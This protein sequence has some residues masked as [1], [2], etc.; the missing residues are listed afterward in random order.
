MASSSSRG[1]SRGGR[2]RMSARHRAAGPAG[3]FGVLLGLLLLTLS[4]LLACGQ[5]APAEGTPITAGTAGRSVT[6]LY[7]GFGRGAVEARD[8]CT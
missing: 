3:R 1:R 8:V 5:V 7:T 2:A 6:I 4:L